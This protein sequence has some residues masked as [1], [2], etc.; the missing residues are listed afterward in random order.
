MEKWEYASESDQQALHTTLET[1][2][3]DLRTG[4]TG[5]VLVGAERTLREA[6]VL[7]Q[8]HLARILF[9]GLRGLPD[10]F[11]FQVPPSLPNS[12]PNSLPP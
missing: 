6:H 2:L 11:R 12:L 7:T 10:N 5:G 8:W 4:G 9:V 3:E 1:A